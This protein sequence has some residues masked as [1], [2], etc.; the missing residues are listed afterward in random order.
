MTLLFQVFLL[1]VEWVRSALF[2]IVLISYN[3]QNTFTSFLLY[4]ASMFAGCRIF[5]DSYFSQRKTRVFGQF[6][7]VR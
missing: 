6:L 4:N 5:Y 3:Y 2:R 1:T 7:L